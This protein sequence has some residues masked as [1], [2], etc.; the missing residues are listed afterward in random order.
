M[1]QIVCALAGLLLGAGLFAL[2]FFAARDRARIQSRTES[3]TDGEAPSDE[4]RRRFEDDRRAFRALM[5]YNADVAYGL[6]R[7]GEEGRP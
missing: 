1:L 5:G 2:G 3:R 7:L 6:E 4:E